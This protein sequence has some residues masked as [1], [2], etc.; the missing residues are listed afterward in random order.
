MQGGDG[1]GNLERGQGQEQDGASTEAGAGGKGL[2]LD[3]HMQYT[4]I[5]TSYYIT[6]APYK[7]CSR[8]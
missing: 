2:I 8:V 5:Y 6:Y 7:Y 3:T 4:Y 1:K